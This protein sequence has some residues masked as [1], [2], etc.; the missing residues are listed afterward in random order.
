MNTVWSDNE[1]G[2]DTCCYSNDDIERREVRINLG[3]FM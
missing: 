1:I 3:F 2:F